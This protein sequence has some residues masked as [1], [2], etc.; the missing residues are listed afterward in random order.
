MA[1]DGDLT[2]SGSNEDE[3]W[4]VVR[5]QALEFAPLFASG[6]RVGLSE[7]DIDPK[8]APIFRW[9][10]LFAMLHKQGKIVGDLTAENV[11]FEWKSGELVIIDPGG[12]TDVDLHPRNM[13]HQFVELLGSYG[14][15]A[16]KAILGGYAREAYQA[17]DPLYPGFT[18]A[19]LRL[20]IGDAPISVARP[21]LSRLKAARIAADCGLTVSFENGRSGA[22]F[23]KSQSLSAPSPE[24][25]LLAITSLSVAG[26]DCRSALEPFG[27]PSLDP[28]ENWAATAISQLASTALLPKEQLTAPIKAALSFLNILYGPRGTSATSQ[29]ISTENVLP[30]FKAQYNALEP[31]DRASLIDFIIDGIDDLAALADDQGQRLASIRLAQFSAIYL[32]RLDDIWDGIESRL[33]TLDMR[34]GQLSWASLRTSSR[35]DANLL[36]TYAGYVNSASLT[37]AKY[38]MASCEKVKSRNAAN[39]LWTALWTAIYE[40]RSL[41]KACHSFLNS[42]RPIE[43][44]ENMAILFNHTLATYM[45][46]LQLHLEASVLFLGEKKKFLWA[47]CWA[48]DEFELRRE[49]Q[50]LPELMQ[51]LEEE[52]LMSKATANLLDDM[53]NITADST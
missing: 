52:G 42:N 51:A 13:S 45:R 4:E 38:F 19:I 22:S 37:R 10:S 3:P 26:I 16:F 9:A 49:L 29:S 41:I 20:V 30:I 47:L 43:Q 35:L 27:P 50:C 1:E 24:E 11:V 46:L 7:L 32:Q 21:K 33:C 53:I 25:C 34:H 48:E 28:S 36:F 18:D 40:Q 39:A 12:I 14:E 31:Q 8:Y 6:T 17:I 15:N 23:R 2:M 44:E 5:D